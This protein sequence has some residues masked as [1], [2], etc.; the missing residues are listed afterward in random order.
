MS[1]VAYIIHEGEQKTDDWQKLREGKLT[2]SNAKKVKGAGSAY[3]YEMLAIM[4]TDRKK[5]DVKTE[6]M[7]RGVELEPAAREAYAA[8]TGEK[9]EQ[10]AFIEKGRVGISP[11][12]VMFRKAG[13]GIRK[14][15]EVKCPEVEHHIRYIVENKVPSEHIDQII[16]GFHVVDDCDE[17]DFVSYCPAFPLKPLHI[18]NVKRMQLAVDISAADVAYG[19]FLK[20][21]DENYSII[22]K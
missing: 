17:I 1:D 9:V 5:K 2:G 14:L 4:T 13:K 20:R 11:D 16:H 3:L 8:K 10:V 18:I 6:A 7:E 12:G 15:L 19:K 22:I 21:L